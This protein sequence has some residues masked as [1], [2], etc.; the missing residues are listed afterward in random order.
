MDKV[1]AALTAAENN[2]VAVQ[3][4]RARVNGR[5]SV[6][7]GSVTDG[8]TSFGTVHA[9]YG[10]AVVA[11]FDGEPCGL[12]FC[13]EPLASGASPIIA[14]LPEKKSGE[15]RLDG[16]RSNATALTLD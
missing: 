11:A 6:L 15:L 5:V 2:A 12:Y 13:G 14:A 7:G 8:Y 9:R 4:L 3:A 10:G 16:A 1:T